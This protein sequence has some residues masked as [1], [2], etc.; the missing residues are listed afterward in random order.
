[1]TL[2]VFNAY[3]LGL[4]IHGT[5]MV[6]MT[7]G[8]SQFHTPYQDKPWSKMKPPE[9]SDEQGEQHYECRIMMENV[10]S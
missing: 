5:Q 1:M 9:I 6:R 10:V 4:P 2:S 8:V 7:L 3:S